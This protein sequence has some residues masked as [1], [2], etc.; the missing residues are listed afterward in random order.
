MLAEMVLRNPSAGGNP[1]PL[2]QTNMR[3]LLENCLQADLVTSSA[4]AP[5][6]ALPLSGKFSGAPS[7]DKVGKSVIPSPCAALCMRGA[8]K[9][10]A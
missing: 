10:A 9:G 7:H 5:G 3:A 4:M 1:V 6:L 2:T 8:K